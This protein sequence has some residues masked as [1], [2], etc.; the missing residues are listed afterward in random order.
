LGAKSPDIQIFGM[1]LKIP[2]IGLCGVPEKRIR[3][4]GDWRRENALT[5]APEAGGGSLS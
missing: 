5:F 1:N 2:P 4:I 3:R